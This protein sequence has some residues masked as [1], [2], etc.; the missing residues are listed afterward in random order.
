MLTIIHGND[1]A[2][3]RKF[4]LEEKKRLDA[5]IILREDEIN[6]TSLAQVLDGGGLFEEVR[7]VFIED[8]L[9]KRQKSIE[10]EA[11][12]AYLTAQAKT[13]SIVLW[14]GKELAVGSLNSFKQAVIKAFKLPSSLF[15]FLDA[16]RPGNGRQLIQLFH[17]TLESTEAEMVFFMLVRQLRIL[18]CMSEGGN[19]TISEVARIAPWQRGKLEGQMKTFGKEKLE[20]LYIRLFSIEVGQKTGG[21]QSS[22]TSAIDFFL[23]EI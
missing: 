18:L 12:V 13:H 3:S 16:L 1:V 5:A 6:L 4:F 9:T 23:A 11:V 19:N 8:F 2:S 15:A 21:L 22:L 20:G 10:K 7:S 17:Q 14:E